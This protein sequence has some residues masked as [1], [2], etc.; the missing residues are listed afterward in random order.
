MNAATALVLVCGAYVFYV[1]IGYPLLL[2]WLARRRGKRFAS[3]GEMRSV[4]VVIPVR[5][6]GKFLRAKLESVLRQDYDPGALDILVVSD[7][8]TDDTE[9]IAS[10]YAGR[11]VRLLSVPQGGKAAALNAALPHLRGEIVVLTDVRQE[12]DPGCLRLL[13]AGFHDP[14]VGVVSGD[15]IILEG[16]SR[17]EADVGLYRRYESWIRANLSLLDSMLGATGCL[18]AIRKELL[19]PF[20]PKTILDDMY[21]PLQVML[22]GYRVVLEARARAYDYPTALEMEFVRKVRTQAGLYQLLKFMPELLS[23]SNRMRWHFFSQKLGRLFLPQVLL[24]ALGA[25]FWLPEPARA[26]VL[27]A[28]ILFYG[29]ALADWAVPEWWPLK[30]VTSPVRTFTVLLAAAFCAVAILFTGPES[31][32]RTTRVRPPRT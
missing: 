21:Q 9:A 12:L 16:Q 10:E 32:W 22:R 4:T 8:S 3:A 6:G 20:P 1:L 27:G 7:G 11:S 15:L 19:V 29:A 13:A 31:L 28:Q 2:A 5:N 26:L 25:S 18:Y 14:A 23:S 30:R 24:V 17:A